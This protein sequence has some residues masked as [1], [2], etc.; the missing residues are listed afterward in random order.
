MNQSRNFTSLLNPS[1]LQNAQQ[2][3]ASTNA[4]AA[5]AAAAAA[6]SAA[7]AN[8][9][10]V[11]CTS[12]TSTGNNA[13]KREAESKYR[14]VPVHEPSLPSRRIARPDFAYTICLIAWF[15]V[16]YSGH[17]SPMC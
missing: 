7:I 14:A 1:Y 10:Q 12:P 9:S 4:A 6:V 8:G 3:A 16:P 13:R 15:Y 2:N 11:N 5:A 17:S